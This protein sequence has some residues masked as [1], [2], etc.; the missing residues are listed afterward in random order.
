MAT[1]VQ[2]LKTAIS[3]L[4]SSI[5]DLED[6]LD[7]ADKTD[8][9]DDDVVITKVVTT[10]YTFNK[11]CLSSTFGGSEDDKVVLKL[12]TDG[13]YKLSANLTLTAAI[14][15]GEDI[16]ILSSSYIA[17]T[18]S[19]TILKGAAQTA[20]LSSNGLSIQYAAGGGLDSGNEISFTCTFEINSD[21]TV[22][23]N[24]EVQA[25]EEDDTTIPDQED[26][27]TTVYEF[28]SSCA[29]SEWQMD[30]CKVRTNSYD[31][32]YYEVL[33][34]FTLVNGEVPA[35]N[36]EQ[37]IKKDCFHCANMTS[38]TIYNGT[39]FMI[40]LMS[41]GLYVLTKSAI[42]TGESIE[43]SGSFYVN[44]GDTITINTNSGEENSNTLTLADIRSLNIMRRGLAASRLTSVTSVNGKTYRLQGISNHAADL[45]FTRLADNLYN[46]SGSVTIDAEGSGPLYNPKNALYVGNLVSNLENGN[47]VAGYGYAN[48]A[49]A[50][51]Y[52]QLVMFN[53]TWDSNLFNHNIG[54]VIQSDKNI[55]GKTV[56][57]YCSFMST[58][59]INVYEYTR[60]EAEEPAEP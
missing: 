59:A 57:V 43:F 5:S 39:D 1:P 41:S 17:T 22:V 29:G 4:H 28:D 12:Y 56:D 47:S 11:D 21:D 30:Y 16:E 38:Y 3:N 8:F 23:I 52:N 14:A 54:I 49:E 37:L 13:S 60:E 40:C 9:S 6:R 26:V 24:T 27:E 53:L 10:T 50:E 45:Y 36:I 35:L 44:D 15:G 46:I 19:Y 31:T 7:V 33:G 18:S 58:Y 25:E 2:L 48:C 34:K 32:T 20:T 42:T 51:A 55:A